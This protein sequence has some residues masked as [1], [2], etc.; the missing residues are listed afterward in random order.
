LLRL[1][2]AETRQKIGHLVDALEHL[3]GQ[4]DADLDFL[5]ADVV[6]DLRLDVG[7][8][9]AEQAQVDGWG[10]DSSTLI[11]SSYAPTMQFGALEN[12][13]GSAGVSCL[14]SLA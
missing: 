3:F 1:E 11:S 4:L 8:V 5:A 10:K 14:V 13:I 7:G 9:I 2:S 12:R 6:V